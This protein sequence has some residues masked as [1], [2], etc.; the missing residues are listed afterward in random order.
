ASSLRRKESPFSD[1]ENKMIWFWSVAALA[2]LGLGWG[3]HAPFYWLLYKLPYF[4]TIRNPMK[5]MHPF[6]LCLLILF[7]Y[8]LQGLW[9]RHVEVT[10][11]I[12][13]QPFEKK[14]MLGSVAAVG[15]VILGFLVYAASS[16]SLVRVLMADGFNDAAFARQMARFS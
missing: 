14:W 16:D 9:R 3:R 15:I 13:K 11:A 2:A 6:H 7:A 4:S 5:F 8:G 10:S 1:P 12:K